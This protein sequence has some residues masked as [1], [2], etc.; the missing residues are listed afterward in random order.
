MST[1]LNS[2]TNRVTNPPG[3][4]QA[5]QEL[6][7]MSSVQCKI[8]GVGFVPKIFMK[9]ATQLLKA[10]SSNQKG[11]NLDTKAVSACL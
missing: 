5:A 7:Y 9:S 2:R 10:A 8:C 1:T 4:T 6:T 11:T 3:F